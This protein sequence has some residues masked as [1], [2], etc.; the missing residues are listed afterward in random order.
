METDRKLILASSSPRRRQLMEQLGLKF[1]I[2]PSGV[3]ETLSRLLSPA[4]AVKQNAYQKARQVA[5]C[6]GEGL[7]I[8]ADTLIA[9]DNKL[10]GKPRS[11]AEAVEM[12]QSLGGKTHRVY[13]GVS[14]VDAPSGRWATDYMSSGVTMKPL[15]LEQI[16][17]YVA[18]GEPLGKAGAYAIQ[19]RGEILIEKIEGC[20]SN[21]VGLPLPLLAEMLLD[22][23]VSVMK[24][25][26]TAHP[27]S[28]LAQGG[29]K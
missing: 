27:S 21:I 26:S 4:E 13:T 5:G 12:L 29:I 23:G 15:T 9:L 28:A 19:G 22:F 20:Y 10:L 16:R 6:L 24:E 14:V 18:T 3:E 11:A 2:V 7:I 25:E 17:G 8:G 1:S